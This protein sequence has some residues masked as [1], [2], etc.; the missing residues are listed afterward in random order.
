[1]FF[2]GFEKQAA[3]W[4]KTKPTPE[5]GRKSILLGGLA[6]GTISALAANVVNTI[7]GAKKTNPVNVIVIEPKNKLSEKTASFKAG[8]EK[9]ASDAVTP[10][11]R[12]IVSVIGVIN[13]DKILLGKRRDNGRWTNPGG[14]LSEGEDPK[15]GAIRE[16][17]EETGLEPKTIKHLKTE[18][19]TTPTGKK[20]V[21]HAYQATI[22]DPKTTMQQDP[23]K[24]VERW[25]W[26]SIK[27]GISND[28][29][30]NLHSPK[31]VLL[32][33]LGLMDYE[34]ESEKKA[35]VPTVALLSLAD[36]LA[37]V[38]G[39]AQR[40]KTK[41]RRGESGKLS[42]QHQPRNLGV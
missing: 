13:D 33:A 28:V 37:K 39:I 5:I 12:K 22:E 1:M 17:K 32:K 20:Y 6:A 9:K 21:I 15:A 35:E 19:V 30:N 3:L 31:N 11:G 36:D 29:L 7:L 8:F 40:E 27:D 4:S 34:E 41:Q 24:E 38:Y 26:I 23:D 42:G 16:L 25:Q 2:V 10:D 14:H 18:N